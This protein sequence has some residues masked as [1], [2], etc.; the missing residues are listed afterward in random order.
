MSRRWRWSGIARMFRLLW[1]RA[2]CHFS[3]QRTRRWRGS[4][5]PQDLVPFDCLRSWFSLLGWID[6]ALFVEDFW[7][8]GH[9]VMEYAIYAMTGLICWS[10]LSCGEKV[11]GG[12]RNLVFL[13]F[14]V[15]SESWAAVTRKAVPGLVQES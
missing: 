12:G 14:V 4:V 15:E 6:P 11:Q 7:Y 13:C 10:S 9:S 5:S 2:K 8:G 1:V 3:C